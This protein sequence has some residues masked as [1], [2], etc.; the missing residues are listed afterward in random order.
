[1]ENNKNEQV[2]ENQVVDPNAEYKAALE[3]AGLS[4][5]LAAYIVDEKS[6][7]NINAEGLDLGDEFTLTGKVGDPEHFTTDDNREQSYIPVLCSGDRD[8][9]SLGRLVGTPKDKYFNGWDD[10]EEIEYDKS[11]VFTM[12]RKMSEACL[13]VINEGKDVRLKLVAIAKNCGPKQ[14]RTYYRFVR[15]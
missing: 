8:S 3:K 2:S 7:R 15:V 9:V 13:W 11:K 4:A 1:M 10:L 12:P 5:K 14:N 6:D